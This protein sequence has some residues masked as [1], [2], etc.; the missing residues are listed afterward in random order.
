MAKVMISIPD[1]D[2]ARIDDEAA[3]RGTSRSA[4]LREAALA[5][6]DRSTS[7][8]AR[9]ALREGQALVAGLPIGDSVALIRDDRDNRDNRDLRR[10][11]RTVT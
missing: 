1:E 6:L 4:L 8:R 5:E 11:G 2:L 10:R 3:R 7:G 9:D